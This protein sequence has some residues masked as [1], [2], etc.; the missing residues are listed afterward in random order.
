MA[1]RAINDVLPEGREWFT[2]AE[3]ASLSLSGMPG[4]K[5]SIN[6]RAQEERWSVR[7][8]ANSGE[9]LVR[10]RVG[11]GGGVEYHISLLPPEARLDLARR[12][13]TAENVDPAE[14]I[15]DPNLGEW[16]WFDAQSEKTKGEAERRLKIVA[17]VDLLEQA[18]MTRTAAIGDVGARYKVGK[19]TLWNW[20]KLV[21]GVAP[22][23][24]LPAIA[25]RR[26]GGGAEADIDPEVWLAFKSD[27][28]APECPTLTSCYDRAAGIAASKGVSIPSE[29]TF[30][31]R[32]E[33]E[34]PASVILLARKGEEA[35]RQSIPAQRRTVHEM[36]ALQCVNIDGHKWDVFVIPPEGGKPV[37][38]MMI[39]I[40]DVYSRKML[41]WR[42][43]LSENAVST[44]LAFADLFE[45]FGIPKEVVL[46]NGRAFNSKWLTGQMKNRFRFKI[47][48]DEP[49]GLLTGLGIKI[50]PTIPYRGQS[51]PIERTF[52]DMCDRIAKCPE[53]RGAYTGNSPVNKPANYGARAIPWAEFVEV[54]GKG[55]LAHNAK[56]GRRAGVCRGRSFDEVFAES[57]K[58]APVGKATEE[59]LRRAL[60]TAEQVKV[61]S[62]TGEIK[63]YGNR[64]WSDGC[65][66]LRGQRVAVR[67]DPDNLH[68]EVHLYHLQKG[69]F[70]TS[71]ELMMDTG[72]LDVAGA[73]AAAKRWAEYRKRIRAG[74][75]AEQLIAADEL[76][77]MQPRVAAPELPEPSVIHPVRHRGQ[78]AAALKVQPNPHAEERQ[79]REHRIFGA[80]RLVDNEE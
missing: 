12:G 32:L 25:P 42:M 17:E 7:Y 64:Y 74:L 14:T 75:E 57:Y 63:L 53:F 28:L 40:Q 10:P 45:N 67:F 15:S 52:R 22:E 8:D 1:S 79:A 76:A 54:V 6:R 18:G 41:A 23:H 3:L 68:R 27:Y 37:R 56:L 33:H 46:D 48:E 47:K 16:R 69:H 29:K 11:R 55:I 39:A 35:L 9:L 19:A 31:R 58:T 43:A 24:R 26:K 60:M 61:N 2:A 36:H 72:F 62:R 77:A 49:M 5:R 34:V 51:K 70:L 65:S 13:L 38:P 73:K 21:D 30:R 59:H 20:L 44:R 80:L 71:A 4:D 66:E 50:H 78:A